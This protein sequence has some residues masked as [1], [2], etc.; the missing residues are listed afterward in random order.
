[1]VPS[2]RLLVFAAAILLPASLLAAVVPEQA[3]VAL[4][5][6]VGGLAVA[7]IDAAVG[8]SRFK[9]LSIETDKAV[10]LN[11]DRV[12]EIELSIVQNDPTARRLRLGLALPP[13]FASDVEIMEVDL[14]TAERS[15]VRWKV[16]PLMRGNFPLELCAIEAASPLGLWDVR[17]R[18]PLSTELRVYPDLMADRRMAAAVFLNR[19]QYGSHA[20]RAM[21]R[22]REFEKLRDYLPG[23]SM[24]EVHWKATARKGRPVTKVFQIERTQEVYVLVDASRL[25]GRTEQVADERQV[26]PTFNVSR[27]EKMAGFRGSI[28]PLKKLETHLERFVSAAL[29][30]GLAAEQ[31]GDHFGLMTFS[32]QVHRF[33]RAGSGQAHFSTCRDALYTLQ[34]REVTPDFDELCTSVRSRLRKRSLLVFLTAL[35]DPILA[36][37]FA[38]NMEQLARQHLVL[39]VMVTP[40]EVRPLFSDDRPATVDALYG[41]LAGHL[42]WQ[43]LRELEGGLRRHGVR[44]ETAPEAELVPRLL[45]QYA[46][47]K[48]RQ[49]L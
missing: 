25:S 47:I 32:D 24:D 40:P 26:R 20:I 33:V 11:K 10:R 15:R 30:L 37:S 43:E 36:E 4:I 42:R 22:G 23:D 19:G 44:F 1:M 18:M 38:R 45:S 31:Q 6:M 46:A 29:L 39:V 28:D 35:D 17:A 3:G 21:G 34:P 49:L 7:V 9:G 12:G 14:K 16:T 41:E 13:E 48:R 5:V 2:Y 8:S 27:Q